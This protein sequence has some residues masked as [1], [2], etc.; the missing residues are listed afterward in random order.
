MNVNKTFLG[1][2][3]TRE[4]ETRHVGSTTLTKFGVA[5]N[6]HYT[7]NGEKKQEATFVDV[8]AWG[9]TGETIAKYLKKGDPIFIEGRLSFS[10]WED[11]STG[12]KR[13]KLEVVCE[14]FQFVGSSSTDSKKSTEPDYGDVPF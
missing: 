9:K 6:R 1:G 2:N 5:T 14:S 10:L 8:L 13:S 11:K 7:A 12:S 3:I 4:P